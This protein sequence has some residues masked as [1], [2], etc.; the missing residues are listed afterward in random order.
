[1]S[2]A[3]TARS[4][5]RARAIFALLALVFASGVI[6]ATIDRAVARNTRL[7]ALHD[8]AFHPLSSLVRA[9]TAVD[10]AQYRAQL[11]RALDLSTSQDSAI[12][13]IMSR[14]SGEFSALREEIRPRVEHLVGDVRA[15]IEKVLTDTQREA[16][17]ALQ[18]R[19]RDQLVSNG[20]AP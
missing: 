14:R 20:Q 19:G 5:T 3:A 9:P 11:S 1:M 12:D 17:R 18:Q 13:R 4:S 7:D 15:D 6:G 10:R 8:T 16:F 2:E